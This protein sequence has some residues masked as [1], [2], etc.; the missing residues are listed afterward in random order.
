MPTAGQLRQAYLANILASGIIFEF[1][2]NK[3]IKKNKKQNISAP[4][5]LSPKIIGCI[6]A[7]TK[8]TFN[9]SQYSAF[10]K[11][12]GCRPHH[13]IVWAKCYSIQK[14]CLNVWDGRVQCAGP[15]DQ[16]LAPV[17]HSFI[18]HPNKGFLDCIGK[19]LKTQNETS[20]W[21]TYLQN[22][23]KWFKGM[24]ERTGSI[25]KQALSQSREEPSF[26]S[27]W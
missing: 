11:L 20:G 19:F 1:L 6:I 17:D 10:L 5:T 15:V 13:F 2:N 21:G 8:E 12:T 22:V 26:F 9:A 16:P 27:W 25:V 3:S 4:S 24:R 18:M 23:V 7:W 14:T